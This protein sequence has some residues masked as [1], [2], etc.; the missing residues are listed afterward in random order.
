M[1]FEYKLSSVADLHLEKGLD[2]HLYLVCVLGQEGEPSQRTRA[3][4]SPCVQSQVVWCY[5]LGGVAESQAPS[6]PSA[7]AGL[8]VL[9]EVQAPTVGGESP[10]KDLKTQFHFSK[11]PTATQTTRHAN[12]RTHRR[13]SPAP[14]IAEH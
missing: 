2:D 5:L 14:T 13:H 4:T 9:Q 8:P 12:S 1:P 3:T 10:P 11:N 6:W 7:E